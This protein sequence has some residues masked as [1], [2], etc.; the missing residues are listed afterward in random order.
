MGAVAG[1]GEKEGELMLDDRDNGAT[2]ERSL[3]HDVNRALAQSAGTLP[4]T[5]RTAGREY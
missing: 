4:S 2:I 5:L 1:D 3:E